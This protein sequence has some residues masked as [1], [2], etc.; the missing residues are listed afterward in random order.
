MVA[1]RIGPVTARPIGL[2]LALSVPTFDT[3]LTRSNLTDGI[4]PSTIS[5]RPC[6]PCQSSTGGRCRSELH[7]QELK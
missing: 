4:Q 6:T 5:A 7:N 2:T 3:N 1:E